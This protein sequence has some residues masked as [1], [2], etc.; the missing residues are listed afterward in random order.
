MNVADKSLSI[1]DAIS[2]R[3]VEA[4]LFCKVFFTSAGVDREPLGVHFDVLDIAAGNLEFLR[5]VHELSFAVGKEDRV[6]SFKDPRSSIG[7]ELSDVECI[8]EYSCS[9]EEWN[10]L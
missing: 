7:C 6:A 2:S 4:N 8:A 1:R 10:E 9:L 3:L 5:P